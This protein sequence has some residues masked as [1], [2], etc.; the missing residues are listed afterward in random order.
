MW[1]PPPP[2][3]LSPHRE[4]VGELLKHWR[5]LIF[6]F[7][8]LPVGQYTCLPQRASVTPP[9]LQPPQ[10]SY[11]R[12][13]GKTSSWPS[14]LPSS[15]A[16]WATVAAGAFPVPAATALLKATSCWPQWLWLLESMG[17]SMWAT[18]ITSDASFPLEM[19]PASWSYGKWPYRQPSVALLP[20][21]TPEFDWV[22]GAAF[23][24]LWRRYSP[25]DPKLRPRVK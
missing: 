19:W 17:A 25:C 3:Q 16:S 4:E 7:P 14:S 9:I 13:L 20:P 1:G 15:P 23:G 8:S 5:F 22:T 21:I 18:S 10:E 6:L 11:T 2:L 24:V 12:A